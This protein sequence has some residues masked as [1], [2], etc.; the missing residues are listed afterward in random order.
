MERR[1]QRDELQLA[2]AMRAEAQ[3]FG[4][5]F[6]EYNLIAAYPDMGAAKKAIDALQHAGI[7]SAEYSL[8]GA[9]AAEAEARVDNEALYETD[10]G[11]MDDIVWHA[12][13]WAAAGI[14]VGAIIG[15]IL[16]AIPGWPLSVPYSIMLGVIVLGTVGALVGGMTH[17]DAGENVD[18]VYRPVGNTHVLVG[19]LSQDPQ[20][21]ERAESALNHVNPLSLHRYDR[22]GQLQT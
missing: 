3:A 5:R 11:M 14:G 16:P 13:G 8:L 21:V 19:V 6:A 15:L 9:T 22:R 10:K 20:H 1:S 4:A 2:D 12:L 17:I 7:E 18:V